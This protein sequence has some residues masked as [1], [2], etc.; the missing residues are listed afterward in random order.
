VIVYETKVVLPSRIFKEAQDKE[1]LKKL[2]LQYMQRY[3]DYAV[4]AVKN[5]FAICERR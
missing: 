4:K 2:V 1:H 5:G 3:P